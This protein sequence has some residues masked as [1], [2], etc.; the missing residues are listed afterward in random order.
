M[1]GPGWRRGVSWYNPSS[2]PVYI[3][4]PRNPMDEESFR[5]ALKRVMT[6]PD[7]PHLR[8]PRFTVPKLTDAQIKRKLRNF[9]LVADA[10]ELLLQIQPEIPGA[11][12]TLTPAQ[13][14]ELL[15]IVLALPASVEL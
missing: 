12:V 14:D 7:E 4:A 3:E 15:R 11:S 1:T 8:H 5:A 13:Q 10:L 2:L 6:P 9:K